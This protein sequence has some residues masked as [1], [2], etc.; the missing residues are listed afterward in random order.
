MN[1]ANKLTLSRI[2][3]IPVFL[4]FVFAGNLTSNA[5]V[6]T[7]AQWLALAVFVGASITD[8][9]DG[10]LARARGMIT[11]FGRLL[12]PLADKLLTMAAF[13]AF[14]ELRGPTGKPIFPAWAIILILAREF[15]VTGLRLLAVTRGRVI[16]ADRWGKHKTAWQIA[17]I[18]TI[19]AGLALR[20]SLTLAAIDVTWFD[21]WLRV[22]FLSMLAIVVVLTVVSGAV[23]V[24]NNRDILL[25]DE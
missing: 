22:L 4:L 12:D 20:D 21:P 1:L 5:Y 10:K 14:V 25:E 8:Y 17:A 9:Y 18:I 11:N 3:V 6:V 19:L 16:H 7:V 2:V 24:I 15:L 23:Y 13:V